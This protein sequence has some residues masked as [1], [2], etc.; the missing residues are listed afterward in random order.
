MTKTCEY[1]RPD[2]KCVSVPD[3][4]DT[5]VRVE[6]KLKRVMVIVSLA[7]LGWMIGAMALVGIVFTYDRVM[8]PS[9]DSGDL[10]LN[11]YVYG[12]GDCGPNG[13]WHGF[14]NLF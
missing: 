14:V 2:C 10:L 4:T 9:E 6:S 13:P 12:D 5:P 7:L 3:H 8:N 1:N 11:C